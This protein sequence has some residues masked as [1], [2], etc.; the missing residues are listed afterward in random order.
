MAVKTWINKEYNAK[1]QQNLTQIIRS[2]NVRES[3]TNLYEWWRYFLC[4]H[5]Q[6]SAEL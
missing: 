4:R 2:C 3:T 1:N 5:Y 6:P